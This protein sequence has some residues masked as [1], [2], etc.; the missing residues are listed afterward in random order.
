MKPTTVIG[1]QRKGFRLFRTWTIRHGQPSRQAVPKDVRELIQTM[2]RESPIWGAP[3]I[4]GDGIADERAIAEHHERRIRRVRDLP[5]YSQRLSGSI[6]QAL[7]Q[8]PDGAFA[9]TDPKSKLKLVSGPKS[10]N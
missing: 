9:W 5:E 3:R 1:W 8:L 10:E 2:S 6:F 4:Y 7:T